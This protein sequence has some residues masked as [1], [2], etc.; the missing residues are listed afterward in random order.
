MRINPPELRGHLQREL[1][2]IYIIGGDELLL[3][4]E[5]AQAIRD[6]AKKAGHDEREVMHVEPGFQWDNLNMAAGAMSLFASKRIL[7]V[8]LPTGKPGDS[9]GKALVRYAENPSPDDVLLVITG[10]LEGS[11][12]NSKWFKTLDKVGGQVICWP[13]DQRQFPRWVEQRTRDKGLMLEPQ[14]LELLVARTEGNLLACAQD[15]DKL[16]LLFPDQIV[17]EEQLLE[18]SANQ[19]RY[20]VFGLIDNLLAGDRARALRMIEGLKAEGEQPVMLAML[21]TRELRSLATR[22]HRL[23][24]GVSI[25]TVTRDVWA[26]RKPLVSK[27]LQRGNAEIWATLLARGAQLERMAK[28]MAPGEFWSELESLSLRVTAGRV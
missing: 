6:A 22:A 23:K 24:T 17:T 2:P 4:E 18:A 25:E 28:G 5:C 10:K 12:R 8:R 14:A 21:V 7:E 19:A 16:A 11:A 15:I 26:K 9:G 3:V 27:A 13:V 20:D 1:L